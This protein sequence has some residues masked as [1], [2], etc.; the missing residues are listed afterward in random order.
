MTRE[1]QRAWTC[2]EPQV[3]LANDRQALLVAQNQTEAIAAEFG[4]QPGNESGHA[5]GA[6]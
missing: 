4:A 5:V 3:Q 1:R 2:C 6:C